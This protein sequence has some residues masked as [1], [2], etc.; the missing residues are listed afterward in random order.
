MLADAILRRGNDPPLWWP[1]SIFRSGSAHCGKLNPHPAEPQ[2]A[3]KL[4]A[5]C[6]NVLRRQRNGSRRQRDELRILRK[7][8]AHPAAK[9]SA[10]CGKA[11]RRLRKRSPHTAG[12]IPA[13]TG[14]VFR[15]LRIALHHVELNP[16]IVI[17]IG[18]ELHACTYTYRV[19]DLS[20]Q[21]AWLS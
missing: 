12:S 7:E 11:F 15:K 20:E 2:T 21:H 3:G 19:S 17:C 14:N 8:P 5:R 4:S 10:H 16:S 18:D 1:R 9:F 6:G 13:H